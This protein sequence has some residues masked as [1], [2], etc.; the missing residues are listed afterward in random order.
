MK[1]PTL[2]EALHFVTEMAKYNADSKEILDLHFL[3]KETD[4]FT[5]ARLLVE[6]ADDLYKSCNVQNKEDAYALIYKMA[7]AK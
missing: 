7:F 1:R 2:P 6:Y 3:M 5:A 4:Q